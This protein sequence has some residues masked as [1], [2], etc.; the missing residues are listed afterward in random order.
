[1]CLKGTY[2]WSA[3]LK[4]MTG[5]DELAWPLSSKLLC[6]SFV[7]LQSSSCGLKQCRFI[8]AFP[9]LIHALRFHPNLL[10]TLFFFF[11]WNKLKPRGPELASPTIGCL[12]EQMAFVCD[13]FHTLEGKQES[14]Q[15]R[16][17]TRGLRWRWT[18]LRTGRSRRLQLQAERTLASTSADQ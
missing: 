3:A 5:G 1:M 7:T 6:Q 8:S 4:S 13:P 14:S 9:L 17:F 18:G 15:A 16:G 12:R 2:G 11:Y 10:L